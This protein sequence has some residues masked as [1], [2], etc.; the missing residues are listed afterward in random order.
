MHFLHIN[1]QE[2]VD[3]IEKYIKEGADVFILIYMEGCGPCNATRPEWEKIENALKQQ[4]KNNNKL[5]IIDINKDYIDSVKSI[6]P[7]DGFPTIKYI[8]DY[9]NKVEV[10]EESGLTN[11][12]RSVDS[13]IQW[14]ET[15]INQVEAT[16]STTSVHS[17]YKRLTNIQN[18]GRGKR[19]NQK[20]KKNKTKKQKRNKTKSIKKSK[21]NK[22]SRENN[23][24]GLE[25]I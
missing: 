1:S 2:N 9:G 5:V 19:R 7:I 4:Y 8:G 14:I 25:I 3:K 21:F 15:K 6:R 24:K 16:H 18:G 23:H 22:R 11:K 10:Y 17:V 12:D 13:F 20:S